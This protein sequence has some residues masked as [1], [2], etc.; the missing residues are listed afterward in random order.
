MSLHSSIYYGWQFL[1]PNKLQHIW[2]VNICISKCRN[3][4]GMT[5]TISKWR[6]TFG[7]TNAI[8]KWRDTFG[9]TNS[10]SKCRNRF[11]L[12]NSISKCRNT[13]LHVAM[14]Y[15]Y[16]TLNDFPLEW[17][18]L[19]VYM[20]YLCSVSR[21]GSLVQRP[22]PVFHT[23]RNGMCCAEDTLDL[24]DCQATCTGT[25]FPQSWINV[26]GCWYQEDFADTQH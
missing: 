14:K 3:T 2:H 19:H 24:I 13:C 26:F 7:M 16:V 1:Y 22:C 23:A 5:N 6:D 9:M 10:I 21:A 25:C 4:F 18:Y 15:Q 11:G 20:G 12:T 8:S 17:A